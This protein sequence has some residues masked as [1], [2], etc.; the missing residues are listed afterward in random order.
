MITPMWRLSA[1]FTKTTVFWVFFTIIL[2]FA[3]VLR[4][5]QL[6]KVP[7]S[8]YWDEAAILV[9]VKSVIQTGRDMFGMPWYHVIF[10][11]YGD[12]KLPVYI[13][14]AS[15]S[16]KVFGLGEWSLRLPSVLAGLGTVVVGGY[17]AKEFTRSRIAQ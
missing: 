3:A 6:G 14:L 11:S 13:W 1:H 15:V 10:P 2:F 16:A 8:L 4:F 17:L 12:F 7:V 9:D 5:Y